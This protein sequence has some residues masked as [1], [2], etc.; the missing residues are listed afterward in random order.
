ML[1]NIDLIIFDQDGTLIDSTRSVW[2]V[3]NHV[4]VSRGRAA[5]EYN[6]VKS[7]MGATLEGMFHS[8]GLGEAPIYQAAMEEFHQLYHA[9]SLQDTTVFSDV[10][11]TLTHYHFRKRMTI[12]TNKP[13]AIAVTAL[14]EFTLEHFFELVVG[15]DMVTQPKPHPETIHLTLE[16]TGV[17]PTRAVLV[18]DSLTD[19]QTGMSAGITTI[20]VATGAHS[21]DELAAANPEYI[22][23]SLQEL[24]NI[25][26]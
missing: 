9:T 1:H 3:L 2:R 26:P 6:E 8:F 24:R 10:T 25:I 19:V 14:Q 16:R 5:V 21:R 15:I 20:A 12:A 17:H 4:L 18:G 13:A 11:E 22:I 7:M 23:D